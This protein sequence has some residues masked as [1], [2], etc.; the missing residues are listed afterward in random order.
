M[1]QKVLLAFDGSPDGREALVQA[2]ALAFACGAAVHLL[3]IVGPSENLLVAEG[4][5]SI[6]DNQQ[7]V[8]QSVLDES[9]RRLRRA[10]CTADSEIRYG[11]PTDR[12]ILSAREMD[13]DL[14][15][16]GHRDQRTLARWFNG[17]IG[18]SILHQAPCSVLVAVKR[19]Q[20]GGKVASLPQVKLRERG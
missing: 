14:I 6:P 19:E 3:A 4:M 18:E 16:I 11:K 1:Y 13:A 12:I 20:R 9:V 5:S 2:E 10:G 7:F 17:S 15:V 8:I